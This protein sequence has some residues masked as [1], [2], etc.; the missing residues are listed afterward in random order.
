MSEQQ[1]TVKEL[2]PAIGRSPWFVYKMRSLGFTMRNG[3]ATPRQALNWIK[4]TGFYVLDGVP[5]LRRVQK[6]CKPGT[7]TDSKQA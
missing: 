4:R 7:L 3:V 2:G 5:K 1:M 6:E